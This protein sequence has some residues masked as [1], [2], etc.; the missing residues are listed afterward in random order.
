VTFALR[1]AEIRKSF[2]GV[3]VLHGVDLE[4]IG[5]SVLA[6]L[7][8]NGAGKSTLVKI[9][10]GDYTADA[11]EIVIDEVSY[12]SLTPI[13]ARDLGV[14]II[15][16]EFQD[17][18]TLTV[19]ENISLGRLPNRLGIVDWRVVRERAKKILK[20]L[21]VDIEPTRRVSTLRVGERQ[22]IEIA[23]ALSRK[24][25][26]LILDEPTAA[27]SH[28]EAETLFKFVRR[29]RDQG[30]AIIYI[31]HRLDE[32]TAIAD[33]V[34]VLRD[35]NVALLANVAE[36]D[37]ASMIQAMVGRRISEI[38]RPGASQTIEQ[39]TPA[40]RWTAAASDDEFHD[41]SVEVRRGEIVAIYGKLGSG[42][43]EVGETA[44]GLRPITAG[45][46]EVDGRP[47]T[48]KGPSHGVEAGVG[49][50]PADRKAGGG[51]MVRPV[52]ENVAVASW[53]R[54]AAFRQ[55]IS[56]RSEAKAYRR[57]HDKLSIRSRNDPRQT[58]GTLSGGNQQKV[59]LARWLE[60]SSRVLVLIEPT[61]GV[62]VGARQ[63]IYRALRTLTAEGVA[64]LISTSDYEE[65]VQVADRVYVMVKGTVVDD[66]TGDSVTTTRL[67][68]A[69]GG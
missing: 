7:G 60:R 25:R 48:V 43:T 56:R 9:I 57:W 68:A 3:E 66:L 37:R 53:S 15:F 44:Y 13:A 16:Q 41:V 2:G 69:A 29:L 31:T 20:E 61:R 33:R 38:T 14:A 59:L 42:A 65:A 4:A 5:G 45:T 10:A 47:V 34:Q 6:L 35:G 17:A 50:L 27:L 19:A 24:A 28:H 54:M 23:R 52:M 21:D 36:T 58:M 11:G 1:A 12:P 18:P 40:I 51:F 55:F 67:L 22:I 30:V 64:V 32:V 26:L 39:G 46:L 8:E 49:F 62:D 63:D